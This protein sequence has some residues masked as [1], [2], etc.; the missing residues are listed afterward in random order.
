MNR[1]DG[2]TDPGISGGILSGVHIVLD[3][4][5]RAVFK[6]GEQIGTLGRSRLLFSL[7]E[8]IL[9]GKLSREALYERVWGQPYRPPSSEAALHTAI[10]RLRARVDLPIHATADAV[11]Y[12]HLTLPTS[13]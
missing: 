4:T 7:L 2:Q 12:T 13:G 9:E 1:P 8:S 5:T 6:N 3:P 10:S 11:S